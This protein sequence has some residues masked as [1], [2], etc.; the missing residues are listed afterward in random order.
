MKL[1]ARLL[2]KLQSDILTGSSIEI[3]LAENLLCCFNKKYEE[4]I[5]SWN[6]SLAKALKRKNS[7]LRQLCSAMRTRNRRI[8]LYEELTY[9]KNYPT[10]EESSEE[11]FSAHAR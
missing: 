9:T 2:R 7:S 5:I 11:E 6:N 1:L 3:M 8:I 4:V 10:H